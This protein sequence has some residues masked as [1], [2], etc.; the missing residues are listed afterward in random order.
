MPP[1]QTECDEI[2]VSHIEGVGV[3][4]WDAILTRLEPAQTLPL[5]QYWL[6]KH[7]ERFAEGYSKVA[8]SNEHLVCFAHFADC[9]IF[10][11]EQEF[12]AP[13]YIAG[14]VFEIFVKREGEPAYLEIH[15]SPHNQVLQLRWPRPIAEIFPPRARRFRRRGHRRDGIR[16]RR[17]RDPEQ[18]RKDNED[19]LKPYMI[20][21]PRIATAAR[22][23]P[24]ENAW[25]AVAFVPF[26]LI[27]DHTPEPGDAYR[28]S[29]SRYDWTRGKRRPILSSSSPH[30][31]LNFHRSG[32]WR[33]LRLRA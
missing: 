17:R 7:Q 30:E 22:L 8:W 20:D 13:G 14:D 16:R 27:S 9:D 11:E 23:L 28:Y 32:D 21:Q 10:N 33:I 6:S 31:E 12:N 25:Q 2:D 29:A 4:D 24:D 18:R 1:T 19:V 3:D 26:D 5:T 15:V